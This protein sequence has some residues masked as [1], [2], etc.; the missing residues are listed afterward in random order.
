MSFRINNYQN[1]TTHT[2]VCVYICKTLL[3]LYIHVA[4]LCWNM[5]KYIQASCHFITTYFST[6]WGQVVKCHQHSFKKHGFYFIGSRFYFI[7]SRFTQVFHRHPI[8][9]VFTFLTQLYKTE[10][11]WI[12]KL[13]SPQYWDISI[14]TRNIIYI[15]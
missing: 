15:I 5:L 10:I 14:S 7:G 12:S 2:C 4:F 8:H 3:Y 13:C 6:D 9:L 11:K 1:Y